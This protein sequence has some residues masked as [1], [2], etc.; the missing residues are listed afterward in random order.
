MPVQQDLPARKDHK[1]FRDLKDQRD[2][3]AH[4]GPRARQ[5][6]EPAASMVSRNSPR[7]A[8]LRLRP[9]L[10]TSWLRCGAAV[11]AQVELAG[12]SLTRWVWSVIVPE[13]REA[14][15]VLGATRALW[16]R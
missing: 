8:L 16:L 5:V 1:E 9:E 3:R 10:H 11:A 6:R 14:P 12:L 13:E 15:G 7:P 4:K 2:R